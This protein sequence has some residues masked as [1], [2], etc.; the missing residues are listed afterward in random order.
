VIFRI[1]A[2][3]SQSGSK[4]LKTESHHRRHGHTLRSIFDSELLTVTKEKV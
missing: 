3:A 4:G 1:L 2:I